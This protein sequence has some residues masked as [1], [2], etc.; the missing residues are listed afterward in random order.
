MSLAPPPAAVFQDSDAANT[1]RWWNAPPRPVPHKSAIA[2]PAR[3]RSPYLPPSFALSG[4]PFAFER[5]VGR[6]AEGRLGLYRGSSGRRLVVKSSHCGGPDGRARAV[7]QLET[8]LQLSRQRAPACEEGYESDT[9]LRA[10][11]AY[12]WSDPCM[13]AAYAFVPENLE[14]WLASHPARTPELVVAFF[15]QLLAIL[16]CLRRR[17]VV[18]DDIK[19]DNFLVVETRDAGPRLTIGDLGGLDRFGAAQMTVTPGRLPPSLLQTTSWATIDVLTSYLVGSFIFSLLLRPPTQRD[20][21][22][23]LDDLLACVQSGAPGAADQCL[24]DFLPRLRAALAPGLVLEHPDV[25]AMASLAFNLTGY[26]GLFVGLSEANR[27]S[28]TKTLLRPRRSTAKLRSGD[29]RTS[30]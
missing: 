29:T 26:E 23:P 30:V 28:L 7:A 17:N 24:S 8:A 27:S 20:H 1:P 25:L 14:E 13:L 15:R 18:Y 5:M 2:E 12:A 11:L 22:H 19:P 16:D 9:M 3:D 4:E 21:Q 6:G 10:P